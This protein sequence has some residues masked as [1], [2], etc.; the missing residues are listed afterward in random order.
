MLVGVEKVEFLGFDLFVVGLVYLKD[1]IK[2]DV[3]FVILGVGVVLVIE[4]FKDNSVVRLEE[5]GSLKVDE[6][7]FVVGFKDVYVI[8]D[9]VLFF[10]YGFVGDGK[11]V[12]I[13]YWN[14]VQ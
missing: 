7:F 3:D 10:Y 13:E 12:C 9:I 4:Y 11:Y 2:F 6:L 14:V 1:G 8:G 5:D